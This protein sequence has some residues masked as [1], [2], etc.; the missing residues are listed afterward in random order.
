MRSSF[1]LAALVAVLLA[2]L[3]LIAACQAV[4]PAGAPAE[5]VSASG[6]TPAAA[7]AKAPA[8]A[9]AAVVGPDGPE[10]I[11]VPPIAAIPTDAAT[12]EAGAKVYA[13]RGCGG[14]HKFG[15]KLV[16]PDLTG[17]FS[18]R[19]TPWVERRRS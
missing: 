8:P 4:A 6:A 13:E 16:G 19:S 1:K 14:C 12:V 7:P 10:S 5:A 15:E 11:V 2:T 17:V 3:G 9:P 18:R